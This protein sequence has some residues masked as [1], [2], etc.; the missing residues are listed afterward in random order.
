[1]DKVAKKKLNVFLL[2]DTSKSMQGE[3]IKQVNTAINDVRNNLISLSEDNAFVDLYMTIIPFSTEVSLY[4]NRKE[5]EVHELS[6]TGLKA[7]GWSNL[8]LAYEKLSH[9]LD[10][11][12]HGGIMPDFGGV[13]PII[14]LL[15]D[16]HPTKNTYKSELKKLQQIPWFNVAL[17][18]GIAI[19]LEDER[20]VNVLKE[21]VGDQGDI[22]RCYDSKEL[23]N[24]I[25]VV[26][27]TASKVQS[28]GVGVNSTL[29]PQELVHA[30]LQNAY[31]QQVIAQDLKETSGLVW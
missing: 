19:G 21:F 30:E 22:I 1:M 9:L 2:I 26:A 8:H 17:R 4:K 6:F 29:K 20:T 25:K 16:G 10:K 31:T 24:I 27:I 3:R 12:K 23:A 28:S 11:E 5:F 18:Y 13:A 15:S 14:I 7:Q